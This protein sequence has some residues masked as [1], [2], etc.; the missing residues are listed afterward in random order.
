MW[1]ELLTTNVSLLNRINHNTGDAGL[2]EAERNSSFKGNIDNTTANERPAPNHCDDCASAV[3]EVDY[4][5]VRA[6]RQAAVRCDKSRVF[7]IMEV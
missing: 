7:R 6:N 1:P 2:P 5:D 4:P 3:V